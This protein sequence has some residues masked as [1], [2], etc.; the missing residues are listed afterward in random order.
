VLRYRPA[1]APRS[2]FSPD[3]GAP[4]GILG[5]ASATSLLLWSEA[6]DNA[7]WTKTGCT[8]APNAIASPDGLTAGDTMTASDITANVGQ[9][10]T[11]TAGQCLVFSVF[12][13]AA[14]NN[15]V[16]LQLAGGGTSVTAWFNLI[17]GTTGSFIDGTGNLLFSFSSMRKWTSNWYRCALTV[18]STGTTSVTASMFP[19]FADKSAAAAGNAVS[20]WGANLCT[21]GASAANAALS[22]YISTTSASVA[23]GGD[24]AAMLGANIDAALYNS[25]EGTLF[26]DFAAAAGVACASNIL[27]GMTSN[28]MTDAVTL[29]MSI[30]PAESLLTVQ[31]NVLASSVSRVALADA[32]PFVPEAPNRVALRFGSTSTLALSLNGRTAL[33]S[34]TAPAL[35]PNLN[36]PY[37]F[38][39][40]GMANAQG[41]AAAPVT[42]RRFGYFSR[43]LTP[44]QL[45]QVTA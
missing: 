31:G 26:L 34:A 8:L 18:T 13:K 21:A 2:W 42:V 33:L 10:V 16:A 44:A 25:T 5:E 29:N 32:I 41:A 17:S 23:R 35:Y 14:A 3:D 6:F 36:P 45:Q 15:Y 38:P 39:F 40:I 12:A 7:A 24:A 37:S 9:P 43:R 20:L 11:I 22:S 1:N 19:C 28:T 27:A 30:D 4:L